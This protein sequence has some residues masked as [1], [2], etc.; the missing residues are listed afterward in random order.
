MAFL[1]LEKAFD[2]D[3]VPGRSS[4]V[5]WTLRYMGLEEW[6]VNVINSMYSGATT[7]VKMKNSISQEFRV[8]VVVQSPLLFIIVFE[9]LSSIFRQRLPWELLYADDLVQLAVSEE[10]LRAMRTR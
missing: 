7:A 9:A 1:D 4:L 10:E 8:K 5:W 3:K 6:I 2:F